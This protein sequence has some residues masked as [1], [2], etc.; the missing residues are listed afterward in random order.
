MHLLEKLLVL[1][2][3]SCRLAYI[4]RVHPIFVVLDTGQS[5]ETEELELGYSVVQG[6]TE[7]LTCFGY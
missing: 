1:D 7:S 5:L 3:A 4:V 2:D 6:E